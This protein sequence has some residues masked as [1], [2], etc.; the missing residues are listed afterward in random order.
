MTGDTNFD[1]E[2]GG[3]RMFFPKILLSSANDSKIRLR[4]RF[5]ASDGLLNA[6]KHFARE[7]L[8]QRIEYSGY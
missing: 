1:D 3:V 7:R 4:F 2:F 6:N 5:W 8:V